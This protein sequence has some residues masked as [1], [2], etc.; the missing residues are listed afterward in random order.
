MLILDALQLTH[1]LLLL[2]GVQ[3][4]VLL[5][6]QKQLK[7]QRKMTE[8]LRKEMEALLLCERSIADRI[9]KQQQQMYGITSRQ[10]KLEITETSQVN[11][12][13]AIALMRKGATTEELVETCDI[14]RG[15]VELISHLENLKQKFNGK[16]AA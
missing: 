11:Y 12:K 13:Q 6:F 10:D 4:F 8:E 1:L 15:E 2:L 7:Q 3:S 16:Y 9:K 14:S 5:R